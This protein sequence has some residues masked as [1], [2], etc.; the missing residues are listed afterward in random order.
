MPLSH[1]QSPPPACLGATKAS[2]SGA[3]TSA[4][5]V[6]IVACRSG[7]W[8]LCADGCE[9]MA[10]VPM[11]NSSGVDPTAGPFSGWLGLDSKTDVPTPRSRFSYSFSR[12]D[13]CTKRKSRA[14]PLGLVR[15]EFL[16]I[17]PWHTERARAW[18]ANDAAEIKPTSQASS[19][20]QRFVHHSSVSHQ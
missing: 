17:T 7:V 9:A 10:P 11:S 1:G 2:D 18:E 5:S 19:G 13:T 14:F 16:R 4:A 12:L 20:E 15:R 6:A 3:S 8:R